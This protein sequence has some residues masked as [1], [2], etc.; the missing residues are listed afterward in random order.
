MD[1]PGMHPRQPAKDA[2]PALHT[3]FWLLV[4]KKLSPAFFRQKVSSVT[5]LSRLSGLAVIALLLFLSSVSVTYANWRPLTARLAADGFDEEKLQLL[6]TRPE[7]KFEPRVMAGKVSVLIGRDQDS[8]RVSGTLTHNKVYRGYLNVRVITKARSFLREH[9][10]LLNKASAS[11]GVP[12]EVVVSILLVETRLGKSTGSNLVF[13]R[14][15][16]MAFSSDIETIRPYLNGTITSDNEDNARAWCRKKAD[17][18]YDEL[19]ALLDYAGINSVDP[20]SIRGSI[21]GAIGLC[22]F[23]PSNIFS[24]GVDA[25]KNGRI[26]PFVTPDAIHSIANYLHKH[27]WT[28]GISSEG[29]RKVI[30]AYNNST[31]YVNTILAVADK[32]GGSKGKRS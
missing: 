29:R 7:V 31:T 27:G 18:A 4:R 24:Y 19:K 8:P 17:W 10:T 14:L 30:F 3:F 25:D 15:A 21:Y 11:Y 5:Y 2:M 9:R 28:R 26:D 12:P 6:F 20:L 22:Q 32:I 13:N 16:S 23:M 1:L